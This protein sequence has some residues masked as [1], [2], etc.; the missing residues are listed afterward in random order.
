MFD[1]NYYLRLFSAIK[2]CTALRNLRYFFK[3]IADTV[4]KHFNLEFVNSLQVGFEI[5]GPRQVLDIKTLAGLREDEIA[6]SFVKEVD[7]VA[8]WAQGNRESLHT[9]MSLHQERKPSITTPN[10][11]N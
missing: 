8:P 9:G 3:S 6:T 1:E 10:S 2:F 5:E 11:Y 7:S 4:P